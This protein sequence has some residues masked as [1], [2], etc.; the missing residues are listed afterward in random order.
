MVKS[1]SQPITGIN[2]YHLYNEFKAG[3]VFLRPVS[4]G[5]K[6]S[7]Q[8]WQWWARKKQI[9]LIHSIHE[10]TTLPPI[11]IYRDRKKSNW[12]IIDGQQRLSASFALMENELKLTQAGMMEKD[13][14]LISADLDGKR[15]NDLSE[16][17]QDRIGNYELRIEEVIRHDKMNDDDFDKRIRRFFHRVNITSGGMSE[18]EIRNNEFAGDLTDLLFS[19]Q[20]KLGF[21]GPDKKSVKMDA[22]YSGSGYYFFTRKVCSSTDLLRMEDMELI[23]S[24]LYAIG[25]ETPAHKTLGLDDF[26]RAHEK[27]LTSMTA[28]KEYYG[29]VATTE[30]YSDVTA[31]P[32]TSNALE[33]AFME[34]IKILEK[35]EVN[36]HF[37]L[38]ESRFRKKNDFYSLF[39]AI[40]QLRRKGLISSNDDL[41][42]PASCLT[43]FTE[44]LDA[45]EGDTIDLVRIPIEWRTN[46]V[47]YFTSLL[48]DWSF[49]DNRDTRMGVF[50]SLLTRKRRL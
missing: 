49:K 26:Y 27:M 8:R 50:V 12:Y 37:T 47:N 23:L 31:K 7:F 11:F 48:K 41:S 29:N 5:H 33:L 16:E 39:C 43:V 2:L 13:K 46:A 44:A 35:L 21:Q 15:W 30:M 17:T 9:Y 38:S 18:Q 19:I 36:K 42:I 6:N 45:V 24:L 22:K 1:F 4:T 25:I 20:S 14:E 34:N 32:K 28:V 40:D 3:R 10:G